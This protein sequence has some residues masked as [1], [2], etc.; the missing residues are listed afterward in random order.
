MDSI[1]GL[2]CSKKGTNILSGPL[3]AIPEESQVYSY[4]MG[5]EGSKSISQWTAK[6]KTT[7]DDEEEVTYKKKLKTYW[8]S[9]WTMLNPSQIVLLQL[10][11]L[12]DYS[13]VP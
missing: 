4:W 12:K 1:K 11:N 13:R 6:G 5:E 9:L 2:K 8:N 10:R 3:H 7:D